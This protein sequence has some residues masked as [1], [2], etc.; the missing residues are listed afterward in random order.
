MSNS[1]GKE[2][3]IPPVLTDEEFE[4]ELIKGFTFVYKSTISEGEIH[5]MVQRDADARFY[6]RLFG[7]Q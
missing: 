4:K 3:G 7:K 5:R 6:N 1:E 2:R